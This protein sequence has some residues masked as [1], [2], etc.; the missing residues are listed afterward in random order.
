MTRIIDDL[1]LNIQLLALAGGCIDLDSPVD[2]RAGD[3]TATE[4]NLK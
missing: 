4:L 3:F 1:L 2:A